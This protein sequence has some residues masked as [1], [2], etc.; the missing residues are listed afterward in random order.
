ML[1]KDLLGYHTLVSTFNYLNQMLYIHIKNE[2][3]I[4]TKTNQTKKILFIKAD[5]KKYGVTTVD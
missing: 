2:I 5:H 3:A 1:A 4:Q